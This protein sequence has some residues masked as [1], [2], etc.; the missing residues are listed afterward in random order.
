MV[1][2]CTS[3]QK[4]SGQSDIDSSCDQGICFMGADY[5]IVNCGGTML[6]TCSRYRTLMIDNY[7]LI[8]ASTSLFHL[9]FLGCKRQLAK[10]VEHDKSCL[11][12]SPLITCTSLIITLMKYTTIKVMFPNYLLTWHFPPTFLPITWSTVISYC[13]YKSERSR[14][15]AK[16]IQVLT[17]P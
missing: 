5:F 17:P 4:I 6:V 9:K 11:I 12:A 8:E 7:E 16:L 10:M 1:S 2:F 13:W 14:R 15:Y 3:L